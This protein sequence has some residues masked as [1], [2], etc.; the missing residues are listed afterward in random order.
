MP[1]VTTYT[2]RKGS[3][4]KT[5]TDVVVVG[6]VRRG[7]GAP[8]VAAGGE[9]VA[10]AYG[11]RL[12]PLLSA[13][14]FRGD[15]GEVLRV[16][17]GDTLRA[18]QL[19]L[20]GL[21][22]DEAV[23]DDAL[24]RAA[25]TAARHL[26]NAASVSLALPM[27]TPAQVGAVAEG[28]AGGSYSF[29][30]YKSGAEPTAV[31]EVSLLSPVARDPEAVAALERAE[32][33]AAHV[34]HAR[35]WVNTPPNDLTPAAFADA[36]V[37][38]AAAQKG[39]GPKV[40]VEVLGPDELRELSCGGVLGVGQG[41]ANEP[42][43]VKLTWRPADAAARLALVGKGITYDSGGL[44]IKPGSSMTTMK[45]DMGGAAT[46][47]AATFAI[48]AL[49]LPV[50]VTCYAPMA[51]NMPSGSAMRPGDVLTMH[52]G[53][54]V[55]VTNT[56]AEGRLLL[57]D[58]LA[59]AVA[60]R[61]DA[62]VDAATLTGACMVALGD[63]YAGV[64]GDDATAGGVLAAAEQAGELAWRL[65]IPEQSRTAVGES[66]VA[67]VLQSNWVRWGGALFAAAF[68]ERFVGDTPWA[69]VDL[70]GPAW[71][72][73]GASGHVPSGATGYGVS[74]LVQYAASLV[75]D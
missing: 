58:A 25:G 64:F 3:P 27:T 15:L 38:L 21:G 26:G 54:T 20:V 70:A 17:T 16:P 47:L 68:L 41:S 23:D 7:E 50:E 30:R 48:A 63:R 51:E 56:D 12:S 22:A 14:A 32:V 60:E 11:R 2:L 67:D 33:L 53:Q 45:Y 40:E 8:A 18:G 19:L 49:G 52:D 4:A 46:V 37:A 73:G 43:L 57:A 61:P 31:G 65:P 66:P 75:V 42:R 55:E 28:F 69:H 44:T 5:R 13:S 39:R 24:R 72:T 59:M 9:E 29:T 34:A 35:D 10:A 62:V 71:N 6:V 74:T 1:R 36:V